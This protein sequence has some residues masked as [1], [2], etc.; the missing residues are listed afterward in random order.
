MKRHHRE[1]ASRSRLAPFP[2]LTPEQDA[3]LIKKLK[4]LDDRLCRDY[5]SNLSQAEVL[6]VVTRTADALHGRHSRHQK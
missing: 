3:E 4:E 5:K 2:D 6:D 1:I